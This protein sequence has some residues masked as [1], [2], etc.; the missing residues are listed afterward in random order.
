MEVESQLH[1]ILGHNTPLTE[2]PRGKREG[3]S[4]LKSKASNVEYRAVIQDLAFVLQHIVPVS[5]ELENEYWT[6]SD[7]PSTAGG[8]FAT[9]NTGN[10]ELL[11]FPRKPGLT[12]LKTRAGTLL[13][14]DYDGRDEFVFEEELESPTFFRVKYRAA[15]A[16]VV[17]FPV[18]SLD[19]VCR[20]PTP[21][22]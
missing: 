19:T 8:R 5:A 15:P 9:L 22:K 10:L 21:G 6:L 1:W 17:C 20:G 14:E 12:I 18:G 2:F 11:Y 7:F 16:D 4:K 13:D 3:P